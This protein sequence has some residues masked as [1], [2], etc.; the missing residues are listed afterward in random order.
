MQLVINIS[1]SAVIAVPVHHMKLL[2]RDDRS[3]TSVR[4]FT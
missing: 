2:E 3:A 1:K 4:Q